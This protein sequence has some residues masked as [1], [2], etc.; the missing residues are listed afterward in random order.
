MPVLFVQPHVL[1]LEYGSKKCGYFSCNPI[2]HG[3][4]NNNIVGISA[5]Y[6]QKLGLKEEE[7]VTV[8][9]CFSVPSVSRINVSP[10]TADDWEILVSSCLAKSSVLS[11]KKIQGY[12]NLW[13]LGIAFF[14]SCIC[15]YKMYF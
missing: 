13:L 8:S 3:I 15:L 14:V 4:N 11:Y 5:T 6:A 10:V 1:K 2:S 12:K 7:K 9:L